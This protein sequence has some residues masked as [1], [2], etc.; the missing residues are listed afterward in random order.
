MYRGFKTYR[1]YLNYKLHALSAVICGDDAVIDAQLAE[2]GL[3]SVK[4]LSLREAQQLAKEL[5]IVA[6]N[7]SNNVNKLK[8]A[9]GQ[10]KMTANQRSAIIKIAKYKLGWGTEAIFSYILDTCPDHRTRLSKW[11]IENSKL[12]HLF[13]LLSS[14]DADKIIKR[15]DAIQKRNSQVENP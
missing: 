2:R 10:G 3:T 4:D 14:K 7:V 13:G 1:H 15:L 5:T 11:E 6:K 9:I 8:E 12:N